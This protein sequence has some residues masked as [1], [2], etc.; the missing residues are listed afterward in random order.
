MPF[1]RSLVRRDEFAK[2]DYDTGFIERFLADSGPE[3]ESDP[4]LRDIAAIA[5]VLHATEN[6]SRNSAQ[7]VWMTESKWKLD[8]RVSNRR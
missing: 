7:A 2:A 4:A 5:S 3:E 6:A 8:A 1:F